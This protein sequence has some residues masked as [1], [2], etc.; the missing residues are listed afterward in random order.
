MIWLDETA[1]QDEVNSGKQRLADVAFEHPLSQTQYRQEGEA[2]LQ[3]LM[4]MLQ[5]IGAEQ[6]AVEI[7]QEKF[8]QFAEPS[9]TLCGR[10]VQSY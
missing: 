7:V 5:E 1:D 9:R 10:L 4:V 2:L 3:Q 6:S 8:A